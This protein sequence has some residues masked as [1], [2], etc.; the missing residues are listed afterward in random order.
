MIGAPTAATTP[1]GTALTP[2]RAVVLQVDPGLE[3]WVDRWRPLLVPDSDTVPAGQGAIIRVVRGSKTDVG[4]PE[5]VPAGEP[6]LK[7]GAVELHAHGADV[8]LMCSRSSHVRARIRLRNRQARIEV[9]SEAQSPDEET[10]WETYSMLTLAAALLLGR[11]ERAVVHAG[12][13]VAPDGGAWLLAGD[14]HAGK[15]TTCASLIAR[16]WS[17]LSDDHVVVW[18]SG[19][20]VLAAGW[21]RP[22]HLDAG[23]TRG[24]P[25]GERAPA[26]PMTLG[27]GRPLASANVRGVLLPGIKPELPTQLSVASPGDALAALI[28]QSP[29]LMA[30][31]ASAPGVLE[32]FRSIVA[33]PRFRLR[34]GLDVYGR[35][36]ELEGRLIDLLPQRTS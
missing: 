28:R 34:L 19:E 31:A 15:S 3:P 8:L 30:D 1:A 7:L 12:A 5:G 33:M 6:Q 27:P 23:W 20:D 21:L 29:W 4:A 18:R 32:L 16:G 22:F 24:S 25:T 26:D 35:P 2:D 36:E 13:V 11:L 17:Y 9:L 10:V 14:T